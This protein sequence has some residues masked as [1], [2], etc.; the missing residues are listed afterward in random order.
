MQ[1]REVQLKSPVA[2][3]LA[4]FGGRNAIPPP[5]DSHALLLSHPPLSAPACLPGTCQGVLAGR[6]HSTD[7][8]PLGLAFVRGIDL[9]LGR[10]PRQAWAGGP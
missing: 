7:W 9:E 6:Y 1:G 2:N 3:Y 10:R 4:A 8:R 5:S